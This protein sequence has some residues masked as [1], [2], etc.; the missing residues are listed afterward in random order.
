M[1]I[2]LLLKALEQLTPLQPEEHWLLIITPPVHVDTTA[3][4]KHPLL[5]RDSKT[6]TIS[7]IDTLIPRND[8]EPFSA[9][10]VSES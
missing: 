8:F 1:V 4:F 10:A 7:E 3:M 9:Q 5:T 2:V 6:I